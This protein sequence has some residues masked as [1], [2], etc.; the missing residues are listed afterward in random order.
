MDLNIVQGREVTGERPHLLLEIVQYR[1]D[2]CAL[3]KM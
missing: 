2:H 3:G 1:N